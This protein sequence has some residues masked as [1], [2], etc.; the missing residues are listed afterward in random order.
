MNA[1]E[2]ADAVDDLIRPKKVAIPMHYNAIVGT[3]EDA[4]K[5]KN[6]VKACKVEILSKD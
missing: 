1:E 2:A 3:E 5:F 6:L 4:K